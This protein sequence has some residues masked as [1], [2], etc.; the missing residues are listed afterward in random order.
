VRCI[1]QLLLHLPPIRQA[2]SLFLD[3]PREASYGRSTSAYDAGPSGSVITKSEAASMADRLMS[4]LEA[5]NEEMEAVYKALVKAGV[6]VGG[7]KGRKVGDS[8]SWRTRMA[9]R[10]DKIGGRDKA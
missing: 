2:G 8:S 10:M 9:Q 4:E 1:E 6:N 5:V 7:W 3:G